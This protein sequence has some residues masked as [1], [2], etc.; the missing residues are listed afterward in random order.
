M[1]QQQ[2][3]DGLNNLDIGIIEEYVTQRDALEA[4]KHFFGR[5]SIAGNDSGQDADY[6]KPKR[7]GSR[8]K[9]LL[10]A[11]IILSVLLSA[12]SLVVYTYGDSLNFRI[13]QYWEAFIN[14]DR[15]DMNGGSTIVAKYNGIPITA[16]EVQYQKYILVLKAN[17][18]E[19]TINDLDIINQIAERKMINEEAERLGFAATEE[20]IERAINNVME[21]YSIPEGKEILDPFLVGANLSFDEYISLL[22]NDELPKTI[23][24]QKLIDAVGMQY[25]EEHGIEFTKLN[26][27][28]ELTAAQDKY[29]ADLFEQNKHK[30]EY[31]DSTDTS[32]EFWTD[33]QDFWDEFCKLFEQ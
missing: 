26:P 21:A 25:C 28:A 22:R 13:G 33:I 32:P 20:E 19:A 7:L 5:T 10:V 31:L 4:K 2:W 27:P 12:G 11:I 6:H 17:K 15:A 23:A 9:S 24:K 29:I 1:N 14:P 18:D 8:S 30:I 16:A 3:N